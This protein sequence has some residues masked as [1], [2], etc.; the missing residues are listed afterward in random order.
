MIFLKKSLE[1]SFLYIVEPGREE[2]CGSPVFQAPLN[3]CLTLPCCFSEGVIPGPP[4]DL[5]VTEATRSYVVLSW[6][7]PGQ[8]GHEGIMYFVEKVRPYHYHLCHL[9]MV[10]VSHI[11]F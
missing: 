3:M 8:R 6:K 11:N 5:S 9:L 1:T 10:F 7:P 4:T 2:H